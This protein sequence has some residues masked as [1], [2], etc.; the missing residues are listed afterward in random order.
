MKQAGDCPYRL[1]GGAGMH[2]EIRVG[3]AELR[4]AG[5]DRVD[6]IDTGAAGS[7]RHA[8]AGFGIIANLIGRV[9]AAGGSRV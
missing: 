2:Q 6:R 3:D 1:A 5:G 7:Y 8:Q 4:V 9:K